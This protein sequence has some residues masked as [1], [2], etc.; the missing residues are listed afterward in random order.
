MLMPKAK[1]LK[2]VKEAMLNLQWCCGLHSFQGV[3]KALLRQ[4]LGAKAQL[5][6]KASRHLEIWRKATVAAEKNLKR[7][8]ATAGRR[9][10]GDGGSESG[11]GD[12]RF[13]PESP[14]SPL[15][16]GGGSSSR[17]GG[18]SWDRRRGGGG[19]RGR[20]G[21]DGAGAGGEGIRT[22]GERPRWRLP[23]RVPDGLKWRLLGM[24]FREWR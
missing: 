19:S 21:G 11:F 15:I 22:T 2:Q 1:F 3:C 23:L 10:S 6:V 7:G 4:H 8:A 24:F 17:S 16:R 12:L 13:G 5:E 9:K 20:G 18:G 14:S